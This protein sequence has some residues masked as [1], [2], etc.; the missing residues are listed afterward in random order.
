MRPQPRATSFS[1]SARTARI[2]ITPTPGWVCKTLTT[3]AGKYA[4]ALPGATVVDLAAHHK[5][6]INIC[7]DDHIPPPVDVPESAK[8]KAMLQQSG[9][10]LPCVVSDGRADIDKAGKPAMVF[11]VIYHPWLSADADEDLR[12]YMKETALS[13]VEHKSGL[14]LSRDTV[15]PKLASK[16]KL[17]PRAVLVPVPVPKPSI[18]VLSDTPSTPSLTADLSSPISSAPPAT[19]DAKNV[20]RWSWEELDNGSGV[21]IEVTLP[22]MTRAHHAKTTLDLEPRHL[23]LSSPAFATLDTPLNALPRD[24]DVD[25][26]RAEFHVADQKLIL[27]ATWA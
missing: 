4:P 3:Q 15:Q 2:T 8:R 6:F 23:T 22:G 13:S 7:F 18:E 21:R 19:S 10:D 16:G 9:W 5:V 20:P 25:A 1:S 14:S 26:A 17:L 24:L 11:D 12:K 27:S